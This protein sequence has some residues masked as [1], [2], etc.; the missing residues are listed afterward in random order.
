M[1]KQSN[2]CHCDKE[3]FMWNKFNK[4]VQCHVCGHVY[5]PVVY[6]TDKTTLSVLDFID[7][8]DLHIDIKYSGKK[9]S[10]SVKGLTKCKSHKSSPTWY[11]FLGHGNTA[12][13]AIIDYFRLVEESDYGIWEDKDLKGTENFYK[14][15]K[16]LRQ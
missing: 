12:K 16:G 11:G 9:Y 15:P 8:F 10:A 3:S 2:E 14:L 13:E 7:I 5:E 1:S 4:V 6:E